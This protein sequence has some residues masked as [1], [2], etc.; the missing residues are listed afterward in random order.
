M[1]IIFLEQ[2][3]IIFCILY[4]KYLKFSL[5]KEYMSFLEC[6]LK[7]AIMFYLILN[8]DYKGQKMEHLSL[9]EYNFC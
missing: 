7:P 5:K 1:L 4:L 8:K 9:H 2:R 3:R 6:L